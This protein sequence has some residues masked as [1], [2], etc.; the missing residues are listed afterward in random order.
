MIFVLGG[1]AQGKRDF[2]KDTFGVENISI[3]NINSYARKMFDEGADCEK[4]ASE[5]INM[6][7][8]DIVISDE[9]GNGIIPVEKS[10]RDFREWMG[11]VQIIIAK[12]ADEVYRVICGIGQKIK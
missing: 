4:A 6:C 11:R 7:S 3:D 1:F 9:I 10:E 12:R 5:L 2:V 8:E